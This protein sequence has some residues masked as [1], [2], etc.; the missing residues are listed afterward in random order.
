MAQRDA[1]C[2]TSD[3]GHWFAMTHCKKCCTGSARA[4]GDAVPCG[5]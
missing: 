3:G 5:I 1:D 2:H 4:V